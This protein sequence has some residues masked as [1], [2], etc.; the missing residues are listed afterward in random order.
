MD[1]A[2][3]G[4]LEE[5]LLDLDGSVTQSKDKDG[6]FFTWKDDFEGHEFKL[7]AAFSA[8]SGLVIVQ[9]FLGV[10]IDGDCADCRQYAQSIIDDM[11]G[12]ERVFYGRLDICE[13]RVRYMLN[14]FY[15]VSQDAASLVKQWQTTA[16][17]IYTAMRTDISRYLSYAMKTEAHRTLEEAAKGHTE[18]CKVIPFKRPDPS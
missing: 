13:N 15:P 1:S 18:G 2:F 14:H 5:Y 17:Q 11:T 16:E 8:V 6:L 12:N 3:I 7:R 10:T 9:G 4:T